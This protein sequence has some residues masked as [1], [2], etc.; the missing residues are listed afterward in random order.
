LHHKIKIILDQLTEEELIEACIDGSQRAC[1]ELYE[2]NKGWLY[3]VCLRYHKNEVD[4]QDSLQESFITIYRNLHSFRAQGSFKGWMR[5]VTVRCILASFRKN[6][7]RPFSD[8]D[9]MNSEPADLTL[10]QSMEKD[11]ILFLLERLPSGR[12]QIFVAHAIDGFTH[13]EIAEMLGIT[14]GTSKSQFFH[15]RR[16]LKE[17]IEKDSV[18]AKKY[19]HE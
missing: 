14:E 2:Q 10:I 17:A 19:E 15:A 18:I 9:G 12:K 8:L 5:K 11:E 1:K 4:A 3:A 6:N 16:E 7:R 13:K